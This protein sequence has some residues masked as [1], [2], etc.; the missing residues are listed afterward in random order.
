MAVP[1]YRDFTLTCQILDRYLAILAEKHLETKFS[2]LNVERV[3]LLCGR[4]WIKVTLTLALLKDRKCRIMVLDAR[5]YKCSCVCCDTLEWVL[6]YHESLRK[7]NGATFSEPR[8]IWDKLH[9]AGMGNC[10][11]E[12]IGFQS[13]FNSVQ[14]ACLFT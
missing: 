11:R 6:P 9:R 13:C 2:K 4:L 3:P 7:F 10:L 14:N 1:F 8:E 12:E 5:T